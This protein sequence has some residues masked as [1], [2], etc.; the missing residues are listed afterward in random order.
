MG[1]PVTKARPDA[2]K[3]LVVAIQVR[4]RKLEGLAEEA[5]WRAFLGRVTAGEVSLRAMNGRQL[6]KVLDALHD[7]GA[8]RSAG[9][10]QRSR[11]AD[12]PQTKMMRGLWI[13]LHQA[14]RVRNP[15]EE[16]LNAFVKR[17]TQQDMGALSAARAAAVIEALKGM[18]NRPAPKAGGTPP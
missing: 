1:A 2:M 9:G 13:E 15:S 3:R 12:D 16:A 11:Y 4:R 18:M 5:D 8:P 14:G 17:Q 7:A 10:P 6:G